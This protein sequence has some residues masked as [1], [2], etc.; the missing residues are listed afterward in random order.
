MV[1]F[2]NAVERFNKVILSELRE[3]S[4]KCWIAGGSLRDYFSGMPLKT[5]IDLF[6][7]N[8]SEFKKCK[9]YFIDNE[10]FVK[11]DSDNGMK[12]IYKKRT[13]DLD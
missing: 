4:I 1:Q 12:V 6:F 7:P 5:D 11:W 8:E 10:A 3:A 2:D 9:A 13:F